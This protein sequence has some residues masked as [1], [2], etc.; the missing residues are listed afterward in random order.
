MR[1][2]IDWDMPFEAK[3]VFQVFLS[4]NTDSAGI[5]QCVSLDR[6]GEKTTKAHHHGTRNRG[7]IIALHHIL[8][9]GI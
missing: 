3:Q 6:V 2:L 1:L 8:P 7:L 4:G 5:P 9:S